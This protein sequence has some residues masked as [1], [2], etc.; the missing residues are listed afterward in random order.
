MIRLERHDKAPFYCAGPTYVQRLAKLHRRPSSA[1]RC[2]VVLHSSGPKGKWSSPL[3]AHSSSFHPT[4]LLEKA[5]ST[6]SG[7]AVSGSGVRADLLRGRRAPIQSVIK[8]TAH[9]ADPTPP[10]VPSPSLSPP[11]LPEIKH[12][13]AV[14]LALCYQPGCLI[15]STRRAKQ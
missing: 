15:T 13:A 2:C 6:A 14:P 3:S 9:L 12:R 1:V 11:Q 5:L 10:S 7:P 4:V 8:H